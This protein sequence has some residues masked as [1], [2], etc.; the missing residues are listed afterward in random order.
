MS[1]LAISFVAFAAKVG[2][3]LSPAQRV[4]CAV[5]FDG[6][7]PKSFDGADGELARELFGDAE[8]I[9]V[10]DPSSGRRRSDGY[11]AGWVC[12]SVA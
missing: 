4:L 5:C 2:M 9:A 12:A 11:G 6:A 7:E 8:T 1:T 3:R 10:P